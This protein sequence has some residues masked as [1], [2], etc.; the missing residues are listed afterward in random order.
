MHVTLLPKETRG[1]RVV[2][3]INLRHGTV[4]TLMGKVQVGSFASGLLSRGTTQLTRQ[5]VRDSLDKLKADVFMGGA[6]NNVTVS[7]ETNRQNIIPVLDLVAQQLRSPRY[8]ADEFEKLK[9]ERLASLEANKSQP[10]FLGSIA[11]NRKLQPKPKGHILYTATPDEQ[12]ADI[13]A[14]TLDQVKAFHRDFYGTTY[15]DIALVGDFDEAAVTSALNRLF[16][17]WK[18]PQPFARAVRTFVPVDSTLESIETPDKANAYFAAAQ[19]VE[20]S[21]NDPDYPAMALAGFMTGGGFLNSRLATRLRQKEGLSYGV[22]AGLSVQT[23]DKYGQFTAS[24][25]YAPQN[26]DRL[27][28]AYREEMDKIIAE[29]FTAQEVNAAK[30]GYVQ[31]RAQGRANDGELVGTLVTRRFAGRTLAW[32]EEFE[33]RVLALTPADVNAAVKKYLDP[34]K[35]VI[36]RAGDFAKNPPVKITP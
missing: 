22:G 31:G 16:G 12:I 9:R 29:G 36:V 26:V 24:A 33:R 32:D 14:V 4:E 27:T 5:Q 10:Q 2:A 25:I 19:L 20:L 28:R 18:N 21:D 7:I 17:D 23:F 1:D 34:K 35:T 30:A 6:T 11:L 15:G 3:Y 13:T 8:D